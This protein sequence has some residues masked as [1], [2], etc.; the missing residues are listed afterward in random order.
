MAINECGGRIDPNDLKL[1]Y[2]SNDEHLHSFLNIL[3]EWRDYENLLPC[4]DEVGGWLRAANSWAEM[5]D[6]DVRELSEILDGNRMAEDIHNV[7]LDP[8]VEVPTHR[9][10]LLPVIEDTDNVLSRF[11]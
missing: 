3:A 11:L 5:L 6:I 4:R 7:S 10:A 8:D 2:V 1:P 9:I